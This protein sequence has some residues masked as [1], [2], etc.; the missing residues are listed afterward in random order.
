MESGEGPML[1]KKYPLQGYPTL[2]FIDSEGKLVKELLGYQTP[3]VLIKAGKS[4]AKDK[5]VL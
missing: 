4:L 2:L 3:E 1:A 5:R